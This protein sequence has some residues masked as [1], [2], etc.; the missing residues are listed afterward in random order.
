MQSAV[1][2]RS[3]SIFLFSLGIAKTFGLG[4]GGD[5]GNDER[6]LICDFQM[7]AGMCSRLGMH[8]TSTYTGV[9]V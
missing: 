7:L 4:G 8:T 1:H 9:N 6:V 5:K 3:A 2:D